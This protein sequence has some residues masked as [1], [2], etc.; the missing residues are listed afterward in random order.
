MYTFILIAMFAAG[1]SLILTG[2]WAYRHVA[3][4]QFYKRAL[5][6]TRRAAN[7]MKPANQRGFIHAFS[8][9]KKVTA[10]MTTRPKAGTI[11]LPWGW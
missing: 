10:G 4:P 11:K 2:L 9:A 5:H 6:R 3:G 1:V 8:F 7:P